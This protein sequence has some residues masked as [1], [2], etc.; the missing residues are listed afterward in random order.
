MKHPDVA[1]QSISDLVSKLEAHRTVGKKMWYRGH[2]NSAWPLAPSIARRGNEP[3]VEEFQFYKRFKQEAA[4]VISEPPTDEWGWMFLMQHYGLPTRLLDFSENP[5]VALYFAV[6]SD[7][8]ENAEGALI[9]LE[10]TTWNLENK[11]EPLSDDDI[12]SCGIDEEMGP[13]LMS[14]LIKNRD[15]ENGNPPLA[16][17]G[18]RNSQRI[19]AQEG[20]F[21]VFHSMMLM[22]AAPPECRSVW[23]YTIAPE[24][25]KAIRDHLAL[26]SI[27]EY[28][29][30]PELGTL[31][32]KIK[33]AA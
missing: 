26:L 11:R 27:S 16:A 13:Y 14:A 21:V 1:I 19:F 31:A 33:G 28:S 20:V 2:G 24:Y 23:R 32:K 17:T 10:P 25:K 9:V 15:P 7:K 3:I 18:A 5:L 29:L 12:P 6:S 8:D 30:F 22:D 4:R